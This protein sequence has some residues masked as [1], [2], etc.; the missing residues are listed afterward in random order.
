MVKAK[1]K[2]ITLISRTF[3]MSTL[4]LDI[5][6]LRDQAGERESLSVTALSP[7]RGISVTR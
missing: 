1:A 7:S 6:M 2:G 4:I 5:L 3:S